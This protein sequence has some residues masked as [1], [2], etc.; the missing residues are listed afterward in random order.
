MVQIENQILPIKKQVEVVNR[1]LKKRLDTVL[2]KVMRETGIDMWLI[3]CQ[4]DN[5]DPVFN[6]MIPMDTWTPILQML[7]FFDRGD[8]GVERINLSRTNTHDLYDV[9]YVVQHPDYQW[10]WLRDVIE[11]RDPK[12]IGIN[13]GNV[14]WAADGL[15]ATLKEKL[16]SILPSKYV[17]RFCSAEDLSRRWLETLTEDEIDL[18]YYVVSIAHNIHEKILSR[19][20]ITP[21]VTTIEDLKWSYWQ[22]CEDLGLRLNVPCPMFNL[23]REESM[24]D[25]YGKSDNTIRQ[26]DFVH[27]DI[28]INYLRLNTD[29]HIWGYVLCDG[30]KDAPESFKKLMKDCNLLEDIYIGEFEQGRTGNEILKSALTKAHKMGLMNPRVY[31]HSCGLYIHEPGPLIGH[32]FEQDNWPG[33]GDVVMNFDSTFVSEVSVDGVVHEWDNQVV[34]FP[35]E[36]MVVFTRDGVRFIDERQTSFYLI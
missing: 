19:S 2:P 31:S 36:E 10:G 15:T 25:K 30:E 9:P 29:H 24:S 11:E 13:Q 26:G 7:I 6:T 16:I 35:L 32:P 4:E 1:I 27:C 22:L 17:D 20:Y 5:L 28:G 33:R 23:V 18:Y 3:I 12:N 8:L 14:I 34:R 21:G